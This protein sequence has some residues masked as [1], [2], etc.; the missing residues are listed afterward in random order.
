[1]PLPF[2]FTSSKHLWQDSWWAAH[3]IG[4][5][6]VGT[7]WRHSLASLKCCISTSNCSDQVY[8]KIVTILLEK[9]ISECL[10]FIIPWGKPLDPLYSWGCPSHF[11]SST[12]CVDFIAQALNNVWG[13]GTKLLLPL[14]NPCQLVDF[15][16][17]VKHGLTKIRLFPSLLH[18][19]HRR[20]T[21]YTLE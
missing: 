8:S 20:H 6:L 4:L 14:N 18:S 9:V 10:K 19:K 11:A 21:H 2:T 17:A 1:M 16:I 12:K 13:L 7:G 3:G 15:S 5:R